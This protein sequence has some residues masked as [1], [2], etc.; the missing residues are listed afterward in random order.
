M[1]FLFVW[2]FRN[3]VLPKM[4]RGGVFGM[5]GLNP[6]MNYV[7]VVLVT[8]KTM[9]GIVTRWM[10]WNVVSTTVDYTANTVLAFSHHMQILKAIKIINFKWSSTSNRISWVHSDILY[11]VQTNLENQGKP[12]KVVIFK[13]FQ[14][15][16]GK[17]RKRFWKQWIIRENSGNF[18][19][20]SAIS[21][22]SVACHF[23]FV[24][25][26]GSSI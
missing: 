24:S 10:Q 26:F 13:V 7:M 15:I 20:L 2:V 6:F 1:F 25:C 8:T 9:D 22:F 18:F 21:F 23:F 3:G 17:L 5:G 19:Y 12:D 4:G 11:S 16:S 14:E